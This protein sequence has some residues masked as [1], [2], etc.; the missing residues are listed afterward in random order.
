MNESN[1]II[2]QFREFKAK[3]NKKYA[4]QE[5]ETA[6]FLIFSENLANIN[7]INAEESNFSVGVNQFADLSRQEYRALYLGYKQTQPDRID[8]NIM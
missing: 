1:E 5:E 8:Y 6:R 3:Y 2:V 7:Q 4:S